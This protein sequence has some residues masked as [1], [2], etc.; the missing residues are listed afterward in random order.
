MRT[1][2]ADLRTHVSKFVLDGASIP[3]GSKGLLFVKDDRRITHA[4]VFN[5]NGAQEVR[6]SAVACDSDHAMTLRFSLALRLAWGH[7]RRLQTDLEDDCGMLRFLDTE[8]TS[9]LFEMA[10]SPTERAAFC[11]SCAVNHAGTSICAAR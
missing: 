4:C 3:T 11:A 7:Q 9:S 8:D 5:Y 10:L 1:L 2:T 6:I